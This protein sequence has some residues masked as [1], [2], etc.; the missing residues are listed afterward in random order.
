[1]FCTK[2][3]SKI[4]DDAIFC[5]KCGFEIDYYIEEKSRDKKECLKTSYVKDI[6]F[7]KRKMRILA[8]V[9]AVA[10][11][12]SGIIIC[13]VSTPVKTVKKAF[14]CINRNDIEGLLTCCSPEIESSVKMMLGFTNI[15]GFGMDDVNALSSLAGSPNLDYE[16][17]QIKYSGGELNESKFNSNFI[18]AVFAQEAQ[19]TFVQTTNGGDEQTFTIDLENYDGIWLITDDDFLN[20]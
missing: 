15:L 4:D 2:C 16:I 19:V 10:L 1:M 9:L 12:Y 8:I 18:A 11:I 5:A 20:F 6:Q 17:V 14:N 7:E 13:R 3:G